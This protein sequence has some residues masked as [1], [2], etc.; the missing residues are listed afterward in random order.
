MLLRYDG[1]QIAVEDV[2]EGDLLLGPDGD[3]EKLSTLLMAK[4]NFTET[5]LSACVSHQS[6]MEAV[7]SVQLLALAIILS[8]R[9][10]KDAKIREWQT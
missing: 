3:L 9:P 1:S 6:E 10:L 7:T 8:G 4:I 2:K 5:K